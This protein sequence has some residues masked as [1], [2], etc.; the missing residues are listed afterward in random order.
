MA[1]F[2]GGFSA[3]TAMIVVDS[4]ALSKMISNDVILLVILRR[5]R[6]AEVYCPESGR[7]RVDLSLPFRD[8][9]ARVVKEF[10]RPPPER[11]PPR[12]SSS[13]FLSLR[14]GT[15]GSRA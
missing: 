9:K 5:G 3:A 12:T 14:R 10:E 4:L 13:V 2:L 6:F 15:V 1:V 7:P 8:A 11:R